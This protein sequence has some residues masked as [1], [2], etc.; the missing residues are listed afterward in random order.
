MRA[1]ADSRGLPLPSEY[2]G[3]LDKFRRKLKKLLMFKSRS[4]QGGYKAYLPVV[5]SSE[6]DEYP[7]ARACDSWLDKDNS[8]VG[9]YLK[10]K[11][12]GQQEQAVPEVERREPAQQNRNPAPREVDP[13]SGLTNQSPL[14]KPNTSPPV[15]SSPSSSS[16]E[17]EIRET[18]EHIPVSPTSVDRRP[19]SRTILPAS[20]QQRRRA[21]SEAT[22]RMNSP[23]GG[24]LE[25]AVAAQADLDNI[26]YQ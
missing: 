13:G 9:E 26:I 19:S 25:W 23:R 5:E 17:F 20:R 4:K 11:R 18:Y 3:G 2:N 12:R 21:A 10:A 22:S 7:K 6:D 16:M 14:P 8:P 15:L 24:I 1:T